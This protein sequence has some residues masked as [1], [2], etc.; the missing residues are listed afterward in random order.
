MS[1]GANNTNFLNL[2][3]L[4]IS[5]LRMLLRTAQDDPFLYFKIISSPFIVIPLI[6]GRNCLVKYLFIL[7][8][9]NG[10]FHLYNL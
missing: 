1:Y 8:K 7:N 2:D 3:P 10:S 4:A 5:E 9:F 6:N